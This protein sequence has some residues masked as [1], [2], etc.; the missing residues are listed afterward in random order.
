MFKRSR[1]LLI[2]AFASVLAGGGMSP[3]LRSFAQSQVTVS[4]KREKGLFNGLPFPNSDPLIG[5]RASRNTVAQGKRA[6]LKRRNLQRHK[7]ATKGA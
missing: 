4:S 2:G 1:A 5:Y 3:A 7:Q 6:A